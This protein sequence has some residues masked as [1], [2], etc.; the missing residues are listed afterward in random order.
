MPFTMSHPAFA[1]PLRRLMPNLS[2]AG[3]VLGSMS[4]DLE[5]FVN[6][7]ARGT[8][9]HQFIG[10]M[11]IGLPLCIA[12]FFSYERVVRPMLSAFVPR[13]F[14]IKQFVRECYGQGYPLSLGGWLHFTAAAFIGY[15]THMFMDAWTHGS[16]VFVEHLPGLTASTLG[17][18]LFQ[19]LQFAFSALGAFC[20]AWWALFGWMNWMAKH[21]SQKRS[22]KPTFAGNKREPWV[23]PWA[24]LIGFITMIIKLLFSVDP[25]DLTL[26]FAAP[27]SA[28]ALGIFGACLLGGAQ[29]NGQFGAGLRLAGLWLA[30]LGALKFEL[31]IYVLHQIGIS[32]T[33]LADWILTIWGFV[34]V[35]IG[36][37]LRMNRIVNKFVRIGLKTVNNRTLS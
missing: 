12:L 23:W 13:L 33:R 14:H 28:A 31:H 17:M 9:G 36:V 8:I 16:G 10:F 5:Y 20:I 34:A 4:P 19:L 29:Q 6:M 18:P 22:N 11:L 1:V 2:V 15:L 7:E 27:F 21:S 35:M 24:I 37:S 32:T 3:L 26:W 25:G 30:L